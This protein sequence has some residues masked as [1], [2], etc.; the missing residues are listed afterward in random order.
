MAAPSAS[1]GEQE[2][3]QR[4]EL[5]R[6]LATVVASNGYESSGISDVCDLAGLPES[7]FRTYYDDLADCFEDVCFTAVQGARNAAMS[8]W[9]SARGWERRLRSACEAIVDHVESSP[10]AARAALLESL[11]GG[12]RTTAAVR[13]A[14]SF[15]ER[16]L[17][18]AF[19]LRRGGFPTSRIAP[20]CIVGGVKR[21][22]TK[23]LEGSVG[24]SGESLVD[25]LIDW[26]MCFQSRSMRRLMTLAVL[27]PTWKRAEIVDRPI[28]DETAD[29]REALIY[30]ML[31]EGRQSLDEETLARFAET[32][33]ERLRSHGGVSGALEALV[34][35]FDLEAKE[36]IVEGYGKAKS[37]PGA[38]RG[39]ARAAVGVLCKD[40]ELSS[41]RMLRLPLVRSVAVKQDDG[42]SKMLVEVALRQAPAPVHAPAIAKEALIGA[43]DDALRWQVESIAGM[44]GFAEHLTFVLLAPHIGADAAAS[45]IADIVEREHRIRLAEG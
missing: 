3:R 5:R 2:K 37:W 27:D 36:A 25:E 22:L 10:D 30:A 4:A 35:R 6:A 39:A 12:P 21:V 8:G 15:N 7:T 34:K 29:I 33:E 24:G 26:I 32:S 18:L 20:R 40:W 42:F 14:L 23:R 28:E 41:V 43:V 38:V 19:Q 16:A 44:R 31:Q 11:R 1:S 9:L 17:V 13:E 45:T